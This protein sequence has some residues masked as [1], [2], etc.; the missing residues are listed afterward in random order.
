MP[1]QAPSG[2]NTLPS[3]GA[4]RMAATW[5]AEEGKAHLQL[6]QPLQQQGE[7]RVVT[8]TKARV[9][10]KQECLTPPCL[11]LF[12]WSGQD[13]RAVRPVPPVSP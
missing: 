4:G 1:S 12:S 2:P 9:I 10:V 5:L 11:C 3:F 8:G 13:M 6:H 7:T